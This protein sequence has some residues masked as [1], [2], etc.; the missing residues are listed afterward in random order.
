MKHCWSKNPK[1]RPSFSH[2]VAVMQSY[3]N[4]FARR[5]TKSTAITM[6][7]LSSIGEYLASETGGPLDMMTAQSTTCPPIVFEDCDSISPSPDVTRCS[8]HT[9]ST[10][11]FERSPRQQRRNRSS[12]STAIT[13]GTAGSLG[14]YLASD[15]GGGLDISMTRGSPSLDVT[16]CSCHTTSTSV[17]D[18][19]P[20][21]S[22]R[23]RPSGR[24]GEDTFL[25]C[26]TPVSLRSASTADNNSSVFNEE[27]GETGDSNSDGN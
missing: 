2:L 10:S 6:S 9:T 27:S 24:L 19:S 3:K 13:I 12:K 14:D 15:S 20:R 25:K 22:R 16:H 1:S 18:P 7:T 21:H 4:G 26:P 23:S 8:C 5:S 17:F 11:V